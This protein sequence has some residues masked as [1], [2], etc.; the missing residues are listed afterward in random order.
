MKPRAAL[1]PRRKPL[2]RTAIKRKPAKSSTRKPSRRSATAPRV[3]WKEPIRAEVFRRDGYRCRLERVPG[4]GRCSGPISYHHRRKGGQGGGYTVENG[5]T[6][7]VGHNDRLEADADL[8]LLGRT[9]GLVLKRGDEWT[10]VH[11]RFWSKVDRDGPTPKLRP[12]LG[13]CWLWLG[14]RNVRSDY[15]YFF[16]GPDRATGK[17]VGAHRFA[18]S[19]VEAL[20]VGLEIDHLCRVRHCVNPRHLEQV[21]HAENVRRAAEAAPPPATC[22]KGHPIDRVQTGERLDGKPIGLCGTCRKQTQR[23]YHARKRSKEK[24]DAAN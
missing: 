14:A 21:T 4:A 22:G 18:L 13:P 24:A 20:V 12:D 9:M 10:D 7:C 23:D 3:D 8:A 19:T 1:P 6:L 15:G 2:K 11:E 5:A 17:R 16:T